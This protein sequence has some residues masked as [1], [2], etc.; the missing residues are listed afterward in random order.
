MSKTVFPL[1]FTVGLHKF[2]KGADD[3]YGNPAGP[4]YDPPLDQPGIPYK[5]AGWADLFLP[6][7]AEV[8]TAGERVIEFKQMFAPS[9]FPGTAYDRVDM[10]GDIYE[11]VGMET[12]HQHGPWWN[13][14]LTM[15]E[16][17]KV[18]G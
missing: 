8:T 7:A 13:P 18:T 17:Q 12:D 15:Y 2:Y 1:N 6:S 11:I 4:L 16:V 5:V 3:G 9:D 10:E 14:G